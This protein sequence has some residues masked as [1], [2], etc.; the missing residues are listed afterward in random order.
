MIS[1]KLIRAFSKN[2]IS[3]QLEPKTTHWVIF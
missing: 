3:I 2:P 1:N